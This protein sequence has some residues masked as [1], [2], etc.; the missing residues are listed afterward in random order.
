[1]IRRQSQGDSLYWSS[2]LILANPPRDCASPSTFAGSKMVGYVY[3]DG[4]PYGMVWVRNVGIGPGLQG[5][6]L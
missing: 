1:M 6:G 3:A 5:R 4:N 2:L